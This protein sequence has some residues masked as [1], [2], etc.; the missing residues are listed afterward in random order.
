MENGN[1]RIR[2]AELEDYNKKKTVINLQVQIFIQ[3]FW[4]RKVE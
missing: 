4:G 2:L 3:K 1:F